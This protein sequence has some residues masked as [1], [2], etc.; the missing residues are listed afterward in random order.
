MTKY[1]V[2]KC[3]IKF[4]GKVYAIDDVID[5]EPTNVIDEIVGGLLELV[6][7]T[8]PRKKPDKS[9]ENNLE[10]PL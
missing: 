5:T 3:P 1:R 8:T 7:S 6:P 10:L 2:T 9:N 4:S